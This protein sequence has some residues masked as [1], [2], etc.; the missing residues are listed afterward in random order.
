MKLKQ[1]PTSL[2]EAMDEAV[3]AAIHRVI[4]RGGLATVRVQFDVSEDKDEGCVV[5]EYAL[6]GETID[7]GEIPCQDASVAS[8]EAILD[9]FRG[10]PHPWDRH[11]G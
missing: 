8:S 2:V 9:T 7:A 10:R 6:R 1:L 5:L 11:R 4:E 3:A